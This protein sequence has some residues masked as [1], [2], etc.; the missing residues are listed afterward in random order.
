MLLEELKPEINGLKDKLQE[1]NGALK[2]PQ[3]EE[4]I[5]DLEH[6]MAAPGFWDDADKAQKVAQEANNLKSDVDT[7]HSLETKI[8]DIETLWEMAVEEND[9]SLQEEIEGE[10]EKGK[11]TL[12]DLELGLLL[13]DQYDSNNAIL[14]LHAGAGGTEAQDWT[15][16]LP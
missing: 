6:Q 3:K 11:K 10:L 12:A 1:M 13:S 8:E 2:I 14:T 15:S 16:M 9:D 7:F 5:Q 4:R